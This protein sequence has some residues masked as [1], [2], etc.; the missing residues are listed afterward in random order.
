MADALTIM[1]EALQRIENPVKW[2]VEHVPKGYE[3]NG[4]ML[5]S[6]TSTPPYYQRVAREALAAVDALGVGG[7]DAWQ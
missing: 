6:M 3:V 7:S 5:I 2:E 4:A 1:R